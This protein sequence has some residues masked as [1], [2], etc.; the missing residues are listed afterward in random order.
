MKRGGVKWQVSQRL[1]HFPQSTQAE[2]CS[3]DSFDWMKELKLTSWRQRLTYWSHLSHG[4]D[5][6]FPGQK[7]SC[8]SSFCYWCTSD[9]EDKLTTHYSYSVEAL[10]QVKQCIDPESSSNSVQIT[11]KSNSSMCF[12]EAMDIEMLCSQRWATSLTYWKSLVGKQPRACQWA[13]ASCFPGG[14]KAADVWTVTTVELMQGHGNNFKG[15]SCSPPMEDVTP[16]ANDNS[17]QENSWFLTTC[18]RSPQ[19]T[20]S[21]PHQSAAITWQLSTI[22]T[23]HDTSKVKT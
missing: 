5:F 11:A 18:I 14:N 7:N 4:L 17:Y 6:K 19:T 9:N 1:A 22:K 21:C 3:A 23:L 16:S 2:T 15:P 8:Y 12:S 20:L 13:A 10:Q